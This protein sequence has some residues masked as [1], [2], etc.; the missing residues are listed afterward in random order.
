MVRKNNGSCLEIG[1]YSEGLQ[2]VFFHDSGWSLLESGYWQNWAKY[3]QE[4]LKNL[5]KELFLKWFLRS[6]WSEQ[7][8]I[9]F[10]IYCCLYASLSKFF[11]KILR[12]PRGTRTPG[13][14]SLS[15]RV[16][17]TLK[18]FIFIFIRHKNDF[19]LKKRNSIF[20]SWFTLGYYKK[21]L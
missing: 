17:S 12:T 6:L 4:I 3:W 2:M 1:R 15:L 10:F 11:N 21:H 7:N 20:W 5:F 18:Y 13:S 19:L 14:E 16:T 9:L 8:C